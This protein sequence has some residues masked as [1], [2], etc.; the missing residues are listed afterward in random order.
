[1][2]GNEGGPA[3]YTCTGGI[4]L[5]LAF[6]GYLGALY[7]IRSYL[8]S[9]PNDIYETEQRILGKYYCRSEFRAT[10]K[11]AQ[12]VD[13]QSLSLNNCEVL[14][15]CV[16]NYRAAI[17]MLAL[18]ALSSFDHTALESLLSS[19]SAYTFLRLHSHSLLYRVAI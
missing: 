15:N 6:F 2:L 4:R 18:L 7:P 19:L 9:R 13:R 10:R 3:Q 5:C 12:C 1:M 14:T 8:L 11:L 16:P 17:L